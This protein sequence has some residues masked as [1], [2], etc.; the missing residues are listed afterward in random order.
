M[1]RNRAVNVALAIMV[2]FVVGA[3]ATSIPVTGDL[4]LQTNDGFTVV[5]DQPGTFVGISA[6]VGTDT[7]SIAS[8]TVTAGAA[9]ELE[10]ADSDLTG[11]TELTNIDVT[12]TTAE[13]DPTDKS[14]FDL[15]GNVQQF[16]FLSAFAEDDGSG[17]IIY[18]AAGSFDL[19]VRGLS[20]NTDY[21][22]E[23]SGGTV[24][25]V[26]QTDG[27]GSMTI[28][29]DEVGTFTGELRTNDPPVLTSLNPDGVTVTDPVQTLSV[30]VD[31]TSFCC[32][33]GDELEVAFFDA[34]DDSQIGSNTTITS[35]STVT[36][37]ATLTTNGAFSW[38]VIATD[39]FGASTQSPDQTITLDEPAPIVTDVSPVD[40]TDLSEGP[41]DIEVTVEDVNLPS[42]DTVQ[43]QF[44]DGNGSNI[45]SQQT[46]NANGTASIQYPGLVGG[47]N[48]WAAEVTDSFGN[49]I[50]TDTFSFRIPS[51]LTLRDANDPSEIIDD[52]AVEATVRFFEEDGERVFPREPTNGVID[53]TGLPV[54]E[55]FVVGVRDDSSTYV[56]RIT[57]ID[58]IFTQQSVYLINTSQPTAIVRLEIEDRTGLFSEAGTNIRIERAVNTVDSPADEER[59]VIVAGDVIGN[60]LSFETELQQDV[61]YRVSIANDVGE[62]RQ[63]GRFTARV[64]QIVPLVITGLDVGFDDSDEGVQIQTSGTEDENAGTETYQFTLVDLSVQTTDLE[65]ELH[66]RGNESNVFDSG[67]ATGP[68]GTFQFTTT[69]SGADADKEWVFSYSYDRDDETVSGTLIPGQ[70][71]FPV[72]PNLD[73]GY[74]TIFG[75]GFIIV[76]TG[77]FS[78]ANAKIG[79][80]IV[81]AVAGLLFITGILSGAVTGLS[82]A[83]AF[84]IGIAYNMVV[85]S[86]GLLR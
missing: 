54:D 84:S 24:L 31:D 30:D 18:T 23:T 85:S 76:L 2:I 58:S 57:L 40:N 34:S 17:D 16:T 22:F 13:I 11:N 68:I 52:P 66:E 60:Q 12:G 56:S 35:P 25:G 42:P 32:A 37:T 10:I 21:I 63:L 78:V 1:N 61:R 64:D 48:Q 41:V 28:T 36:E 80:I 14:Q 29:L 74:K 55:D 15:T 79:A 50:T 70:E 51:E 53:M 5:L 65:V 77:I 38:Y 26:G 59:Y 7:V 81:P 4:P 8:G 71:S 67:G 3:A 20:A 46:L 45:G 9:G 72:L 83:V 86:R 69:V 75:V 73:D 43:V 47:D 27:A 33:S 44:L 62:V 6:F 49:S 82:I 19:T 39:K